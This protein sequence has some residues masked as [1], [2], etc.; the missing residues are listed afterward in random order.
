MADLSSLL[1]LSQQ[2]QGRL[3]EIQT[4][5]A[6]QTL[7]VSAG[8]G[9][10]QATVDGRGHIRGIKIDPEAVKQGDIEMLEDLVLAAV[11]E[12]QK[13]AAELYQTR[14]ESWRRVCSYH[15]SC[16][17]RP[18]G[19]LRVRHRRARGGAREDPR[20]R[21]QDRSTAHVLFAEAA[22]GNRGAAGG[23]DP[24][25][26]RDGHGVW[27]VREPLGRGSLPDLPRPSA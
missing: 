14:C 18:R 2:M 25:R 19:P 12:A 3:T 16:R 1:Q 21:A 4:Q 13:R 6:Q 24:A 8:G 5:L 22:R 26:P 20:H 10:V 15:S 17:C 11:A 9:M 23:G 7:T 27:R